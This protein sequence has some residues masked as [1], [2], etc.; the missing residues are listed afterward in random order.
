V[1]TSI[2][3]LKEV[4]GYAIRRLAALLLFLLVT[5]AALG[6]VSYRLTVGR[7]RPTAS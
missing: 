4:V 1:D 5:A 2:A 7:H 6:V 3:G